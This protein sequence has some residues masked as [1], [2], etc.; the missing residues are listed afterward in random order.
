MKSVNNTCCEVSGMTPQLASVIAI[1]SDCATGF[2]LCG[3]AL[4]DIEYLT[5]PESR[6]QKDTDCCVST[7]PRYSAKV[8]LSL[9]A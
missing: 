3:N 1:D 5:Q 9:L 8:S 4:G 2:C 6:C 7:D